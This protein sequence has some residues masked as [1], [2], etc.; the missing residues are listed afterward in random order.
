LSIV[1]MTV[2][3]SALNAKRVHGEMKRL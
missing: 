1:R 3:N 2:V